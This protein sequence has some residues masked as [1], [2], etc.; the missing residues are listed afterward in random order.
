[1]SKLIKREKNFASDVSS[2]LQFADPSLWKDRDLVSLALERRDGI[3]STL[4]GSKDFMKVALSMDSSVFR[5][6]SEEVRGDMSCAKLAV[7]KAV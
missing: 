6:G 4:L 2:L 7:G 5:L 1:M 3:G